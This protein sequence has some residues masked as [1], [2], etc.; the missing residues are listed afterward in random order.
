MLCHEQQDLMHQ[1]Y[2]TT[3]LLGEWSGKDNLCCVLRMENSDEC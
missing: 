1:G 3:L 2:C